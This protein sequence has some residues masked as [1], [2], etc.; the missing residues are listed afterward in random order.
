[1]DQRATTAKQRFCWNCGADMGVIEN[2][3]YD[4][5]DTCGQPGCEREARDAAYAERDEAHEQLDR[6]LGWY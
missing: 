2:K 6:D 1:M 5:R 3:F 4:S